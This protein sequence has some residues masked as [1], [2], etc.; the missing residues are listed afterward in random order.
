MPA[1]KEVQLTGDKSISHRAALFATL[2]DKPSYLRNFSSA[3]DCH[4]TIKA[5]A[6]LGASV[7]Q[8]S[9]NHVSVCGPLGHRNDEII[10]IDAG[11]SGTT[12]RLLSGLLVGQQLQVI[13]SGD[14]SLMQRPM[15]RIITPLQLMGANIVS[16]KDGKAPLQIE[17]VSQLNCINYELPLAS[18]QVKSALLLA[19]LFAKGKTRIRDPF[20]TRDHTERMLNLE[21]DGEDIVS[22]SAANWNGGDYFI[23]GDISSAA[24]LIAL[25]LLKG[26]QKLTLVDVS[27]NHGRLAFVRVLQ[28]FG[29]KIAVKHRAS[30]MAEPYG[31]IT[32]YP[33]SI[34]GGHIGADL[35]PGLI[36][37][38]P[39]LAVLAAYSREGI[40]FSGVSEL[41]H[42]ESDRIAAVAQNL[43]AFGVSVASEGDVLSVQPLVG[44][45]WKQIRIRTFADHRIAM[46]MSVAQL[47]ADQS[48]RLDNS[49]CVSI[50]MPDFFKLSKEILN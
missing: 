21:V 27:L 22:S 6:R 39:I 34:S 1:D 9:T 24:F 3:L 4:T 25:Q 47:A 45:K 44:R 35:V 31:D 20:A 43:A 19:G 17:P 36:D 37:E 10:E 40:T 28:D 50:S 16:G 32:V 23:P 26:K 29:A 18:A 48:P 14:T 42:K 12:M 30:S 33:G 2:A 11:N 49:Q 41:R 8:I 7:E 5:L 13:L 38:I 15:Q 46:A